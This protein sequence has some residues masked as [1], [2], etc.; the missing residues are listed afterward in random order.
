[1]RL[2]ILAMVQGRPARAVVELPEVTWILDDPAQPQPAAGTL[3]DSIRRIDLVSGA[4][5]VT[6]R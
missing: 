2:E 1:M 3:P 6:K 5:R 4:G